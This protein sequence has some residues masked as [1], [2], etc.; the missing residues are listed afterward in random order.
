[1]SVTTKV[2]S[3]VQP[4]QLELA[5]LIPVWGLSAKVDRKTALHPDALM[6]IETIKVA[7]LA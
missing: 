6:I 5:Q 1:M 2:V 4:A 3:K 7:L